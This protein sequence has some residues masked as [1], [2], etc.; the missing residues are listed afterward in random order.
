MG[1]A[2][3]PRVI[4]RSFLLWHPYAVSVDHARI[5]VHPAAVCSSVAG[6]VLAR[7]VKTLSLQ[8]TPIHHLHEMPENQVMHCMKCQK[9]KL[10]TAIPVLAEEHSCENF[11]Y[12]FIKPIKDISRRCVALTD[13]KSLLSYLMHP[14]FKRIQ[15]TVHTK[16]V[17]TPT[18]SRIA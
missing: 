16:R 10:C 5:S 3:I 15:S 18:R 6:C 1:V 11:S 2:S 14:L 13:S 17:T 12:E 7:Q 4:P 8:D 9:I